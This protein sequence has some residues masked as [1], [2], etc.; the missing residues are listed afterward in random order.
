MSPPPNPD[1]AQRVT[2]APATADDF[3]E[4]VALRIAAMRESLERV[5]RFDSLRARERLRNSFYP[6]HTQFVLLDGKKIGFYT[7]RPLPEHYQ[8]DHLYVHPACQSRGVGSHVLHRLLAQADARGLP[9]QLGALRESASNRFYQRHGFVK[10]SEDAWDIYY[11]RPPAAKPS[12]HYA[13]LRPRELT[14]RRLACPV[15]YLPAGILEWHGLHNP[16]GLDGIKAEKVLTHLAGKLGGV[17]LPTQYW[18]DHRA[19][20]VD[21]ICDPAVSSFPPPDAG[22]Q[23]TG[24]CAAMALSRSRLEQEAQRSTANG[25]WRLWQELIVHMLF[26]CESLGFELIVVYPGHYPMHAPLSL[27]VA[28]FKAAGGSADVFVLTDHLVAHGDHAAAFET[29]LLLALAPE[30]VDLTTLAP[31]A[32]MHLGVVGAD[33]L[34]HASAEVGRSIVAKFEEMVAGQIASLRERAKPPRG[35][36][37]TPEARP[38]CVPS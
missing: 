6:E 28:T 30:L 4:L 31:G 22:D 36:P 25:G 21:V 23:V 27:A 8:L 38:G 9:V 34:Q 3:D 35:V 17:V 1:L 19:D 16:L 5:G 29:S 37:G 20:I 26:Q 11:A 15:A 18:G 32:A 7:F 10:K 14:Q 12:V 24:I 2:F 33:P 13:N